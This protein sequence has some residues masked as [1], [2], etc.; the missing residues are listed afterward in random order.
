MTQAIVVEMHKKE[1][2]MK[3]N[4]KTFVLALSS[5]G[6]LL[7]MTAAVVV[8][9]GPQQGTGGP[10]PGEGFRRGPRPRDGMFPMLHG[11]NL[12]DDQKAQIKTIIDN[13]AANTRELRDKL[14]ALHESEADPFS[15]T[16]NEASVRA[17]AE[18]RAKIDIELQVA[19]A[20]TM[21]QIG[22]ILTTEQKAQLASRRAQFH[23]GPPPP[24]P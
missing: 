13:E 12:S 22:A 20:R 23:G 11:L 18:A 17:D 15:A 19:H 14:K 21:S 3:L 6:A 1:K 24:Q 8:S 2:K 10:P 5:V 7:I 4:W 16:F 9:Q